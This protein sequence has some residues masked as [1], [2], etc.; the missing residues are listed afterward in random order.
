MIHG[1][2]T[3][4]RLEY[5]KGGENHHTSAAVKNHRIIWMIP[6]QTYFW[7]TRME[8]GRGAL[9]TDDATTT[10]GFFFMVVN[11]KKPMDDREQSKTPVRGRYFG[12]FLIRLNGEYGRS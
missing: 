9:G 5:T 11:K 2:H 8:V 7:K 1:L 6:N 12:A 3:F 4:Y 10:G